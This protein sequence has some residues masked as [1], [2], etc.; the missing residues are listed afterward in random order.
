MSSIGSLLP[1]ETLHG[2]FGTLLAGSWINAMLFA[3][4]I[5]Q[6]YQYFSTFRRDIGWIRV[7]VVSMFT[8]DIV[9]TGAVCGLA[10]T[11]RVSRRQE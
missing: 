6:V 9:S 3:L 7:L 11:V 4:E 8:I 2:L 10:Y 1:L 5:A